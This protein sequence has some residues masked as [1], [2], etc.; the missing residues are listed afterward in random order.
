[1]KNAKR[2]GRPAAEQNVGEDEALHDG[3]FGVTM[4]TA[5]SLLCFA[6]AGDEEGVGLQQFVGIV[7]EIQLAHV[8]EDCEPETMDGEGQDGTED[9]V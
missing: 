6:V 8:I 5:C 3:G 7:D 4:T 2:S 9:D 1:M